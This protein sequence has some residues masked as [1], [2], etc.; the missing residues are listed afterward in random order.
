MEKEFENI[1]KA[2]PKNRNNSDTAYLASHYQRIL[3][4]IQQT[5]LRR[6]SNNILLVSEDEEKIGVIIDLFRK[7]IAKGLEDSGLVY[8]RVVNFDT[9]IFLQAAR[10]TNN[11]SNIIKVLENYSN[12]VIFIENITEVIRIDESN[13]LKSA[14]VSAKIRVI[15]ST[16]LAKYNQIIKPDSALSIR[17]KVIEIS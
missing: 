10:T 5:L 17:F 1:I 9:S 4:T 2:I 11:L 14:I 7:N 3:H 15:G 16:T 13:L 12:S 6:T 8:N